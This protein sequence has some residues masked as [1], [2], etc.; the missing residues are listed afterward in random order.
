[1]PLNLCQ[2]LAE[3]IFLL[4]TVP[5]TLM[6]IVTLVRSSRMKK[7]LIIVMQESDCVCCC[8]KPLFFESLLTTVLKR[9]YLC[10]SSSRVQAVPVSSKPLHGYIYNLLQDQVQHIGFMQNLGITFC[11]NSN[12]EKVLIACQVEPSAECSQIS[13]TQSCRTL[14][15]VFPRNVVERCNTVNVLQ[16][17]PVVNLIDFRRPNGCHRISDKIDVTSL[18]VQLATDSLADIELVEKSIQPTIDA[19]WTH[20]L[21]ECQVKHSFPWNDKFFQE[22]FPHGITMSVLDLKGFSDVVLKE[23]LKQL[24]NL[25]IRY[26]FMNYKR[27]AIFGPASLVINLHL[28][29]LPIDIHLPIGPKQGAFTIHMIHSQSNNGQ[30]TNDE[31]RFRVKFVKIGSFQYAPA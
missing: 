17:L 16:T 26:H 3:N 2:A 31:T 15:Y 7:L 19:A 18:T 9:T 20:D 11:S 6:Q 21:A 13:W 25:K 23:T 14:E 1:M 5:V 4:P 28:A 29:L 30:S 24:A 10:T 8:P 12:Q 27:L 22:H